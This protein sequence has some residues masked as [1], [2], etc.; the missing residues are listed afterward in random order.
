MRI[1][2]GVNGRPRLCIVGVPWNEYDIPYVLEDARAAGVRL[3]FVDTAAALTKVTTQSG[4]HDLI[5]VPELSP[6]SILSAVEGLDFAAV[7]SITELTTTLA[8]QV[9]E[10]IHVAGTSV[11][12]E[13]AVMDKA[14]CRRLLRSAGLTDVQ[15][16]ETNLAELAA[17]SISMEW[18]AVFKP[19]AFTGSHG[20]RLL[21]DSSDLRVA[22]AA[23][24]QEAAQQEGRDLVVIET[25]VPGP[26]ISA[27]AIVFEGEVH[28]LA[29]Q[30]K[31]N[32]GEP[33]F[34]ETGHI[35][36]SQLE[37]RATAA[38]KNFLGSV[39]SVLGIRTSALHAELKVTPDCRVE[40][41]EL[42]TR[43]GG[44]R[45][46]PLLDYTAGIRAYEQY[47][48]V[49]ARGQ[50]PRIPPVEKHVGRYWGVAFFGGRVGTES[51]WQ[52]WRFP[53]ARAVTAVDYDASRKPRVVRHEGVALEY[54]RTGH[55]HFASS[56]YQIVR[57]NVE[58]V[59]S[60]FS[61]RYNDSAPYFSFEGESDV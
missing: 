10:R 24:D 26:E 21:R 37:P 14:A 36:P 38:V 3:S 31:F 1:P 28:L 39:C 58:Y 18:P 50:R 4:G 44:D 57:R 5:E 22:C 23:F 48:R 55:I 52:A 20:V 29:M 25:F 12:T 60:A 53:D 7:L 42:H 32:T 15:H 8:A 16:I 49:I 27:E 19:R 6:D 56:D 35:M 30:D 43:F 46:V 17:G 61:G 9:R 47:F 41:I 45:T 11:A 2:S 33:Q 59:S 40:L 51:A 13:T 54:W 34:V